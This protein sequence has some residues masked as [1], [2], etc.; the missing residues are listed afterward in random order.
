MQHISS[1]TDTIKQLGSASNSMARNTCNED[2]MRSTAPTVRTSG[3]NSPGNFTQTI[4]NRTLRNFV[5]ILDYDS[6]QT[7][8]ETPEN[9]DL[10]E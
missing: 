8:D 6:R 7:L 2:G 4:P 1:L 3:N 5:N 10:F 9:F